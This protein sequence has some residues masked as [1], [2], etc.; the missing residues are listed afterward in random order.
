MGGGC[1]CV[2]AF[3]D[4]F[5][6]YTTRSCFFHLQV[7]GQASLGVVYDNLVFTALKL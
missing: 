5:G 4:H 1:L 6:T 3:V 2:L 7:V